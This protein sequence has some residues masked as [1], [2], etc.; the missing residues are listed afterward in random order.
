MSQS[1]SG[2]R[3]QPRSRFSSLLFFTSPSLPS[4]NPRRA[5]EERK[6]KKFQL[7]DYQRRGSW[8]W[9]GGRRAAPPAH[10]HHSPLHCDHA[11]VYSAVIQASSQSSNEMDGKRQH[12]GRRGTAPCWCS[13][14]SVRPAA[15]PCSRL[16]TASCARSSG[17]RKGGGGESVCKWTQTAKEDW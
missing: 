9:R 8:H 16:P 11:A 17:S 2:L 5:D 4:R 3:N 15:R 13:K 10:R 7:T 12:R 14:R 6:R 1:A